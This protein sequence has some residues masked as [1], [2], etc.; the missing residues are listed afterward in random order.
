MLWVN[1]ISVSAGSVVEYCTLE[2]G[3]EIGQNCIVSNLHV[4]AGAQIPDSSFLHTAAVE[5]EGKIQFATF[6]F[7]KH[8]GI[9]YSLKISRC[10]YTNLLFLMQI[11]L[12]D[13]A[14]LKLVHSNTLCINSCVLHLYTYTD[15]GDSTKASKLIDKAGDLNYCQ[16]KMVRT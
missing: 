11:R 14:G 10:N 13:T 16:L 1:S 4:P 15:M 5:T 3:V 6:A 8:V 7:G 9:L 12:T 2:E